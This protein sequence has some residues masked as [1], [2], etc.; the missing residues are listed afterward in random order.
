MKSKCNLFG[1][2]L[3][4]FLMLKNIKLVLTQRHGTLRLSIRQFGTVVVLRADRWLIQETRGLLIFMT[5]TR[6]YSA[7]VGI[8][9]VSSVFVA[10]NVD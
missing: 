5:V 2:V 4:L 1:L 6:Y 10:H 8:F 7:G 3:S 9:A